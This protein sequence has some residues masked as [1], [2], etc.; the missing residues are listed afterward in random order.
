[1][2]AVAVAVAVAVLEGVGETLSRRASPA[3][4][5]PLAC[6][7]HMSPARASSARLAAF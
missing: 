7:V 5:T 1:M 4:V 3:G 6:R 2:V